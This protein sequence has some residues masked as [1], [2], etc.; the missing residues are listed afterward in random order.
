MERE[1]WKLLYAV[2]V[3][4][5]KPWGNWLYAEADVAAVYFWAVLNDRPAIWATEPSNWD[6]QLC[7]RPL[8]SQSR[9]SRR[10]RRPDFGEFLGSIEQFYLGLAMTRFVWLRV[11]DGKS[12]AVSR[13]SKDRDATFGRGVGGPAKGYKLHAVW[14]GGPLPIAWQITPLHVN[15]KRIAR[16]LLHNLP[17]GGYLLADGEYDSN[18]LYDLAHESGYQLVTRKIRGGLG[19]RRHSVWRLRSIEL[20]GNHFGRHLYHYR[21]QI[22]RDFANF[23]SYGGGLTGLPPWVRRLHRV[24][25]WV[26]AKL[27]INA[28]RWFQIHPRT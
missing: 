10:L 15:E 22:E 24:R 12:L 6:K 26:H 16:G 25:N 9:L 18:R 17:G 7:P 27:L 1:F 11:I 28:L 4:L 5:D 19:H 21:K 23:T 2:A 13:I 20:L 14:G 8:I 3:H